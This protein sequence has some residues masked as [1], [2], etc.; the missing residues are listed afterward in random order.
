MTIT[1]TFG[2]QLWTSGGEGEMAFS[3][4]ILILLLPV[5]ATTRFPSD[6]SKAPDEQVGKSCS[7]PETGGLWSVVLQ[8]A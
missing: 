4:Q 7:P 2:E 8:G 6:S 5:F 1:S 3:P